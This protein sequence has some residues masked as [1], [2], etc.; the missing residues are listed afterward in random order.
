[1]QFGFVLPNNWGIDD[2]GAVVDLA[3]RAEAAGFDSVWVNH[4]LLNVGYVGDRLGDRTYY[5][6]LTVL[7]WAAAA[8]SRV[9]LGT[10]VLVIAYLNP[11][12]LAKAIATLDQLSGG[13]V[14]CGVGVGSLPEE[15]DAVGVVAYDDR[16]RYADEF[17]AVMR[18]LW[19]DAEPA[20]EGRF[21]SF[22]PVQA[23]HRSR[24]R[25]GGWRWPSAATGRRPSAAWPGSATAGTR[26]AW[27][28]TGCASGSLGST[29]CSM[30][31][32]AP[33]RMS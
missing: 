17:I 21:F 29:R 7:T 5:D 30:S 15:N 33:A 23:A 13:R 9:E 16:G 22:G 24:T 2:A 10:S 19:D 1:M 31:R 8:T 25:A 12:V 28:P 4:H 11:F 26:W 18:T 14:R 3:Q 20:Y 32:D 6:A 27:V